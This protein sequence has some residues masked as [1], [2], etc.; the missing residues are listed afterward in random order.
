MFFRPFATIPQHL[1]W[2]PDTPN[3]SPIKALY[4]R[5]FAV[6]DCQFCT[7]IAV[8]FLPLGILHKNIFSS[9]SGIFLTI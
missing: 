5:L 8:K 1:S 6:D 7:K 2:L 3:R 9:H 4:A